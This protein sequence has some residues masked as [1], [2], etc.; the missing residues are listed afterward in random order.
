M[1][2][3][4]VDPAR[5]GPAYRNKAFTTWLPVPFSFSLFELTENLLPRFSFCA[6]LSEAASWFFKKRKVRFASPKNTKPGPKKADV[7]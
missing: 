2:E 5:A 7:G 3:F 4:N 6:Y 1:L